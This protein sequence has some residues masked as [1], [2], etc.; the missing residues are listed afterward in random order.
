MLGGHLARVRRGGHGGEGRGHHAGGVGRQAAVPRLAAV[1][2][3]ARGRGRVA[4]TQRRA[5]AS[6]R[7]QTQRGEHGAWAVKHITLT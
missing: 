1:A 6:C 3:V 2:R 7:V 5:V 4:V